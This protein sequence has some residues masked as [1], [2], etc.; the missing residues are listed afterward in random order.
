MAEEL[1]YQ[2]YL[3]KPP[4]DETDMRIERSLAWLNEYNRHCC[5]A[6]GFGQSVNDVCPMCKKNLEERKKGGK[7]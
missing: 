5:G 2:I 1:I 7:S 6:H 4:E 3:E